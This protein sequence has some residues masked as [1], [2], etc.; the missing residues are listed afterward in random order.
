MAKPVSQK[1]YVK[2]RGLRCPYCG[3]EDIEGDAVEIDA[4]G[5]SQ[6]ITCLS[7]GARWY[8][9]YNLVGYMIKK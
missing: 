8:D 9:L 7:C 3:S 2:K 1:Q 5:A 4:G 6:E